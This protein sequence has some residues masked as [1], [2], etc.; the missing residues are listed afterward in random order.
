[1]RPLEE[2]MGLL[3]SKERFVVFHRVRMA[4]VSVL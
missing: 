2:V 4:S 3:L 1:V